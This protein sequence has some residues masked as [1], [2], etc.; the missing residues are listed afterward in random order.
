MTAISE[1]SSRRPTPTDGVERAPVP[2]WVRVLATLTTVA[3]VVPGS[4]V[5]GS[6]AV[7][8]SWIPPRGNAMVFLARLWAHC[9]LASAGVRLAVEVDPAVDPDRGYVFLANHQSYFDIPAL[10][11]TLPGTVRF[12]A[13]R[14]LFKIPVFGWA[15]WAGG[16]I[17]VDR[18]DRSRARDVYRAAAAR[19]RQ[20]TSVLF[21]PEGT[22]SATG[23]LGA[24]QRGGFLVAQK[25]AA[26]IVPVGIDGTITVLPRHRY[27]I[28][29]TTVRIKIGAPI[30][31]R[32]YPVSRKTELIDKVR[33]EI[34][35]L[36][37]IPTDDPAP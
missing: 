14:N 8:F 16:F 7:L 30:D 35:K 22:R 32:D 21:F 36:A 25:C 20:G 13:K 1:D 23:D 28:T 34:A 12:A 4:L 10:M 27:S 18:K 2:R 9:L 19:L 17:P 5:M 37:G 26:S 31:T 33:E 15:L 11:A 3:Y 24:F 29:P 6:L